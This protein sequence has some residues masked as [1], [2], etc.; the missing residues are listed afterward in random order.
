MKTFYIK[1]FTSFRCLRKRF[2][3]YII[4]N[5]N[6]K[7]NECF[8]VSNNAIVKKKLIKERYDNSLLKHFES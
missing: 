4:N 6:F 5:K 3:K 7:Y 2:K 8:Y 1:E